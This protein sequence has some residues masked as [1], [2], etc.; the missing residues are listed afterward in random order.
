[1]KNLTLKTLLLTT[2]LVG[3]H[4]SQTA[5]AEAVVV[6]A[7][8]GFS[9]DQTEMVQTIKRIYLKQ[10]TSWPDGEQA[11][12]FVVGADSPVFT[13][14]SADVLGMSQSEINDHWTKVK[15][16]DGETP[17]REIGSASILFRQIGRKTGAFGLVSDAD[18]ANLPEGVKILFTY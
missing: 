15:Q 7:A 11:V 18:A 9:G 14:F 10:A 8:N 1:M 4:L 12:P 17:P 5:A 16:T 13:K 2:A 3:S 6:N